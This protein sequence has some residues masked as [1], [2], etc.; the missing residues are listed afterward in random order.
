MPQEL[1]SSAVFCDTDRGRREIPCARHGH[2]HKA[3]AASGHFGGGRA[4]TQV[5]KGRTRRTLCA[6]E[7]FAQRPLATTWGPALL[8]AP[9]SVEDP[10]GRTQVRR[11]DGS[12]EG[13]S[14]GHLRRDWRSR[15]ASQHRGG[16]AQVTPSCVT[17]FAAWGR[18]AIACEAGREA[19]RD[20]CARPRRGARRKRA[21]QRHPMEATALEEGRGGV[22]TRHVA[23]VSCKA[24]IDSRFARHSALGVCV[25][26]KDPGA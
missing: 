1:R 24:H 14:L 5:C 18:E 11:A 7:H 6:H 16:S 4:A 23:A 19:A 26:S 22:R 9:K 2:T 25:R 12:Q 15:P 8:G 21:R 17:A 20:G 3:C 10:G 13:G